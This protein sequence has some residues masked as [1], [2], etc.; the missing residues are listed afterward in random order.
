MGDHLIPKISDYKKGCC[1]SANAWAE[2][3]TPWGAAP[4]PGRHRMSA[5]GTQTPRISH[6]LQQ[7]LPTNGTEKI[8]QPLWHILELKFVD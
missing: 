4:P 8:H 1:S 6:H 2:G 7:L 5:E 3:F